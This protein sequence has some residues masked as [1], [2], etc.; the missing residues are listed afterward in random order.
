MIKF[1]K[2]LEHRLLL[3]ADPPPAPPGPGGGL[4]ALGAP[5]GMPPPPMGGGAPPP[6]PP[7]GGPPMPPMGSGG[8]GAP[9][10]PGSPSG[11]QQPKLKAYNVWDVLEDL[12]S[13]TKDNNQQ[14]QNSSDQS[15]DSES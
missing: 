9:P 14:N 13:G 7:M 3:E 10:T 8:L 4:G 2:F 15:L 6:M 1:S 12:L 11:S 5:A